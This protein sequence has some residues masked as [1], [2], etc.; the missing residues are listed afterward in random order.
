MI[1][2]DRWR[3][4]ELRDQL[5]AVGFPQAALSVRGMGFKDGGEDVRIFRAALVCRRKGEAGKVA[6]ASSCYGGGEGCDG[7]S[8]KRETRQT[9][10]RRKAGK[11]SG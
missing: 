5:D 4:A 1:V 2:C 11:C 8:G 6:L 3:E 7:P 9:N 10:T